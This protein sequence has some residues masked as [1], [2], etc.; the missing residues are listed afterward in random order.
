MNNEKELMDDPPR[1]KF[2]DGKMKLNGQE[3]REGDMITF[4]KDDLVVKQGIITFGYYW[5][6]E[7]DPDSEEYESC[8]HVGFL[9]KFSDYTSDTLPNVLRKAEIHG[10]RW[11][12]TRPRKIFGG[13]YQFE[14]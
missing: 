11:T 1:A 4:Y 10:W 8:H 14:K 3:I 12:I 13:R 6:R 2:T 9:I 7:Y 5:G